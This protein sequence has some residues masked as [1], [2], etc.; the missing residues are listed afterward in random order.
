MRRFGFTLYTL[1]IG[2]CVFASNLLAQTPNTTQTALEKPAL[3]QPALEII[4]PAAERADMP[5]LAKRGKY[6][7]GVKTIEV[8][9][10]DQLDVQNFSLWEDRKLTLEVWYP[11]TH[12][13]NLNNTALASYQNQTRLGHAFNLQGNAYRDVPANQQQTYPLIVLSHGYT[14]YRT[15]MFYLGEHLASHG[16]VVAAIDHTDSTNAEVNFTES[17]HSGF[18]STLRNRPRDQQFV[19]EHFSKT[20]LKQEFSV[21]TNRAAVVGYS[22]GG[23]GALNTVGGCYDLSMDHLSKI[24]FPAPLALLAAPVLSGCNAGLEQPDPRWKAMTAIAP[25]GQMFDIHSEASL[26]KITVPSLLIA[27]SEDDVSGYENGVKKIYEQLTGNNKY[28]LVYENARHNIAPHPAPQAAYAE[29]GDL[30]FYADPVWNTHTINM[31]NQHMTLAFL[32]CHVKSR[33]DDCDMLP[34]RLSAT[35]TKQ[36][37]GSLTQAWPGFSNRWGVGLLFYRKN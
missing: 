36:P 7:V 8:V 22:M 34:T 25:W 17:P 1:L 9:N 18:V 37:D 20:E 33:K 32:N 10:P 24:G 21:D 11:A 15:I 16:Y 30:S 31:V 27:G 23:Y 5:A 4:Y 14:G 28:L 35:Q 26:A 3:E 29:E 19:L 6:Q 2:S 12:S 13:P